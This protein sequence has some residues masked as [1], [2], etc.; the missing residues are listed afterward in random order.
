MDIIE[1]SI[2]DSLKY[3][4]ALLF[5]SSAKEQQIIRRY[6]LE[7]EGVAGSG[8]VHAFYLLKFYFKAFSVYIFESVKFVHGLSLRILTSK[9]ISLLT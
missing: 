7:A 6:F 1:Y 5:L 3:I 4:G 8:A 9:H 2:L